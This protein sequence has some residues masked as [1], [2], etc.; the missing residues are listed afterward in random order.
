[1]KKVIRLSSL[2]FLFT[3]L[4]ISKPNNVFAADETMLVLSNSNTTCNVYAK[5]DGKQVLTYINPLYQR[6][7]PLL[8][9][10]TNYYKI[11]VSGVEG[12]I[13]KGGACFKG[14]GAKAKKVSSIPYFSFSTGGKSLSG[15]D[16]SRYQVVG[17]KM[18]FALVYGNYI[19]YN[20]GYTDVPKGL[21]NN[22]VYYSYD[23]IYYYTNYNTM[24]GDYKK[25]V[26]TRAANASNPYY[27]YYQ[28][29][30][31]RSVSK[32]STSALDKYLV[33]K[34]SNAAQK[35]TQTKTFSRSCAG[36]SSFTSK[37]NGYYSN[38]YKKG[39]SFTGQQSTYQV[40]AGML[41][42]IMLNESAN[43]TS[44][45]ARHYNNPFGWGAYD[46]CP[47]SA[48]RYSS[49][50]TA[51]AKYYSNMSGSYANP[52]S[53]IGGHG[54]HLGNKKAG[55]NVKYASD[56]H[57]GYKNAYNYRRVDELAGNVDKNRLKIGII[58]S[59][60]SATDGV[61]SN[62]YTKVY[63]SASTS[64][65]SPYYYEKNGS[66]VIILGTSGSYYR[67]QKDSSPNSGSVYIPKS[68][69]Y[70][71]NT[72]VNNSNTS[73]SADKTVIEYE[74]VGSVHYIW[75]KNNLGQLG[76]GK[77]AT[78]AKAN[79]INLNTLLP[80]GEVIKQV[81]R[82]NN[83]NIYVL[84]T[85]GNVYSSGAN[86]YGQ[87]SYTSK[88]NKFTKVNPLNDKIAAIK[89]S[90]NRLR[91]QRSGNKN[92][93]YYVG[94]KAFNPKTRQYTRTTSYPVKVRFKGSMAQQSY[95]YNYSAGKVKQT[96]LYTTK[97]AVKQINSYSYKDK[98]KTYQKRLKYSNG[99]ITHK[100]EWNYVNGKLA[101]TSKNKATRYSTYYKKGKAN[102][103]Y[104]KTYSTKGKL[105]KAIKI[106]VRK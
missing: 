22:T 36:L 3:I 46:S 65:K 24:V 70:V 96:Y 69:V 11:M 64:A 35:F 56:P 51:I 105:G 38:V 47:N 45:L 86:N 72:V 18:Y 102:R 59:G 4:L 15:L 88:A 14:G 83:T 2:L 99:K 20:I 103:T 54:T 61:L 67:I 32:V 71:T 28:Y 16:V 49:M 63:A 55:A 27:D 42:G 52:A 23:G 79:R 62:E 29:V 40:N 76:N 33:Q 60:K 92:E 95:I 87:R 41:Y 21:K 26:R 85:S 10:T 104:K 6:D 73:S 82:Y 75:G 78:L 84:C 44:N 12:W 7:V 31:M 80:K 30:P 53:A 50:A 93:Y 19:T 58:N 8:A 57:W 97:G 94:N 90:S 100:M 77:T 74:K 39:S 106:K 13:K 9:S 98:K 91:M 37:Y 1:M 34:Q 68:K 48:T 89:V 5:S 17:N 25:K 101:S 81:V 43:G 66:T